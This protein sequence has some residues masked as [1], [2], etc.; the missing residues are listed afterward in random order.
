MHPI[1]DRGI[2]SYAKVLSSLIGAGEKIL[3]ALNSDTPAEAGQGSS[4]YA[5][6]DPCQLTLSLRISAVVLRNKLKQSVTK[7][8]IRVRPRLDCRSPRRVSR[9][10]R[11]D[12]GNAAG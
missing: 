11:C 4:D 8:R 5:H 7:L 6:S 9:V 10:P 2:G 1:D 12:V 3:G